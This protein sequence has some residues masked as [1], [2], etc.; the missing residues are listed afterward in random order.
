MSAIV[1]CP[2]VSVVLAVHNGLAYLRE[3]VESLLGQTFGDFELIAVDD[4]STDRSGEALCEYAARDG[5]VIVLRNESNVGLTK[6]LNRGLDTARGEFIAR[7]DADDVSEPH[8]LERQVEYLSRHPEVGLLGSAYT[9]ILADGRRG[10]T[11]RTPRTDTRIRWEMLFHNAFCHSTV[12]LRRRCLDDGRLRYDESLRYG[13]D[14][15]M[16]ARVLKATRAANLDEPLVCFRV[17]DGSIS[18]THREEQARTRP[19]IASR[20]IADVLPGVRLTGR[21]LDTLGRW[22]T[23]LPRRSNEGDQR[24]FRVLLDLLD[25]FERR[26]DVDP[27]EAGALCGEWRER[28]PAA[29]PV[30]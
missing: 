10:D 14:Y 6:S 15:E 23:A 20:Q 25:A 21:E 13:Q 17:H 18:V 1:A 27:A 26:A 8:R 11:H 19:A 29:V 5:R 30:A 28:I 24:L 3:A 12:M 4:G 22:Y 9:V 7:Q 2:R 16:W